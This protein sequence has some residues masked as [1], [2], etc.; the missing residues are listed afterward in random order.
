M[1]KYKATV[2]KIREVLLPYEPSLEAMCDLAT[3]LLKEIV[4]GIEIIAGTVFDSRRKNEYTH[5]WAY[6][7]KEHY[8]VDVTSEQFGLPPCLCSPHE[9]DFEKNGYEITC[10]FHE[11]N[12]A[13]ENHAAL[14]TGPVLNSH[15]KLITFDDLLLQIKP[16]EEKKKSKRWFFGGTR[17][18]R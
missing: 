9:Y 16:K 2:E 11:W 17:R 8:Y 14:K 1:Y 6:D 4:P 3:A 5:V 12:G 10:N 15:G 13:F 7:T 18:K